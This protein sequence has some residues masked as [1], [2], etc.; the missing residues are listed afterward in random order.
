VT[1][2]PFRTGPAILLAVAVGI[3]FLAWV[4]LAVFRSDAVRDDR[5]AD[6]YSR[7]AIGHV[8]LVRTLKELDIPVLLSRHDSGGRA[9]EEN[10]LLVIE[11]ALDGDY[12]PRTAA[13]KEM[14]RQAKRS[15]VVLPKWRPEFEG[16]AFGPVEPRSVAEAQRVVDS[17][18]GGGTVERLTEPAAIDASMLGSAT[19]TLSHLPLQVVNETEMDYLALA[20]GRLLLGE[21][22]VGDEHR[23]L[24]ADPDVLSNAGLHRPG[25]VEFVVAAI[26]RLRAGKG[27][28]VIDETLHGYERVPSVAREVLSPPLVF[29]I[30]HV[31]LGL[32][33][34]VWA[35]GARFGAPLEPPPPFEPGTRGLLRTT[36]ELLRAGGH[37]REA[38]PR[39]LASILE[40]ARAAL[41]APAGEGP[42]L[43]AWLDHVAATRGA[44]DRI[45]DL[46][47]SVRIT[48]AAPPSS[49]R[50]LETALRIDRWR[51]EILDGT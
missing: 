25:N 15:L 45:D 43:E 49:A 26:E 30:G 37:T 27:T 20:G 3:S 24:L 4:L 33:V 5:G 18:P 22:K 51:Q 17:A 46:R 29:S 9:S 32:L 6:G 36:A 44:K 42:E 8:A 41:H 40:H 13:F 50:A 7:L 10:V 28:V 1:A 47:S 19:P 35:A 21:F 39:Y 16:I 12:G 38:L 14:L 23:L 34:L 31:A 48:V 11:P 2:S